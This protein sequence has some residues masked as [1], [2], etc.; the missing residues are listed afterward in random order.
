[1]A[2][3][4]AWW[5][6]LPRATM[7]RQRGQRSTYATTGGT[8]GSSHSSALTAR[9]PQLW[10]HNGPLQSEKATVA[11]TANTN[12]LPAITSAIGGSEPASLR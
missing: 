8:L 7:S 11:V 6:R 3:V 4:P 2:T 1:M 10:H 9:S 5:R 12:A